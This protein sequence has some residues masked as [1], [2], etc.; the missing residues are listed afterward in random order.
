DLFDR[1]ERA[2]AGIVDQDVDAA[3]ALD[4]LRGEALDTGLVGDITGVGCDSFVFRAEGIEEPGVPGNRSDKNAL[5]RESFGKGFADAARGA[6]K[7]T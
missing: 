7:N 4:M 5:G 1:S 3:E 2:D 6:C